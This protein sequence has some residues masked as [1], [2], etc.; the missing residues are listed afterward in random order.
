M[1]CLLFRMDRG[2]EDFDH[3]NKLTSRLEKKGFKWQESTGSRASFEDGDFKTFEKLCRIYSQ[4][5]K[6][7]IQV[8][9]LLDPGLGLSYEYYYQ[10]DEN[11]ERNP[12]VNTLSQPE[13]VSDYSYFPIRTKNESVLRRSE[14]LKM[15]CM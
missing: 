11:P 8:F 5:N 14:R 10:N 6:V 4:R 9:R 1:Y 7:G 12:M 2:Y 13:E 3:R 15:K